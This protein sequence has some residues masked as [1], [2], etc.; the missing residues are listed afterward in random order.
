[1]LQRKVAQP[2]TRNHQHA[3]VPPIVHEVLHSPGQPL[4]R[5]TR[6][7]MEP[8][9]GHDFSRVRVH[10]DT[11]AAESARAVDAAAYTVGREVVFGAGQYYPSS[12]EGR[13][14]LVHELAHVV[15]Q[16]C[17]SCGADTPLR[18]LPAGDTYEQQANRL[19][20]DITAD[21]R[22][23][24][25][26]AAVPV[27]NGSPLAFGALQRQQA[28]PKPEW[29][30]R[31]DSEAQDKGW[32]DWA[33]FKLSLK[34]VPFLGLPIVAH[35]NLIDKLNTA[36]ATLAKKGL[37]SASTLGIRSMSAFQS[38]GYHGLHSFGVAIDIDAATNPYVMHEANESKLDEQLKKVYER[39]AQFVLG[40]SSIIPGG[41]AGLSSKPGEAYDQLK[42]ETD[43]MKQYFQYMQNG[44]DLNDYVNKQLGFSRV[45]LAS[46]FKSVFDAYD[47]YDY[48]GTLQPDLSN[49][50][51]RPL[52][53]KR[54]ID[55]IRK[56]MQ[57]DWVTL[58]GEEGPS[59][60][61]L[62]PMLGLDFPSDS[63]RFFPTY[64]RISPPVPDDPRKGSADRPF[65]TKGGTYRGRSPLTGFL[66]LNKELVLA[67]V[68]AGLNW[69]AIGFGEWSGD[70]MHFDTRPRP[71]K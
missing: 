40:K 11:R 37:G 60:T 7:F 54:K 71:R 1:M 26:N 38:P 31:L 20:V 43:A 9:L 34:S 23:L 47:P 6:E 64:P 41:L 59:L 48:E 27:L 53:S 56:Q 55:L 69:G 12:R 18:I 25:G 14:L 51:S 42:E 70:I 13:R 67:L 58:T 15:Q 3:E 5:E 46:T 24:H 36:Q 17:D 28:N 44:Q 16:G 35:Q 57:Y 22:G 39:I 65:D 29:E 63:L 19:A 4:D 45:G 52:V 33:E 8:R 21:E 50:Y 61:S 68:D 2:S 66:N 49:L 32:Q 30:Q 62:S 10:T